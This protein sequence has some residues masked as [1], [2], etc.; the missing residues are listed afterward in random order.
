[1]HHMQQATSTLSLQRLKTSSGLHRQLTNLAHLSAVM[2][3]PQCQVPL[4][5]PVTHHSAAL[6]GGPKGLAFLHDLR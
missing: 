1:M 2:A 6:N 4:S 3:S 5:R